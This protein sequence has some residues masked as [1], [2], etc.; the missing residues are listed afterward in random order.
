MDTQPPGLWR[1]LSRREVCRTPR[2]AV[3]SESVQLPNGRVV[4]DY[5]QFEMGAFAI[6]VAETT[7]HRTICERQYKHGVRQVILTLPGGQL[8]ASETPLAA[9][10]R[11]LLE[12]TGY[13]SCEWT[14]LGSFRTN[15]NQ[16]GAT[17]HYFHARS[18][19]QVQAPASGDLEDMTIELLPRAELIAAIGR[20]DF[21]V[22]TDIAAMC[23]ALLPGVRVSGSSSENDA[24]ERPTASGPSVSWL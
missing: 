14:A 19:R 11:E 16:G 23:L 24:A 7:D 8:E 2:I 12:E 9:A 15:C 4:D 10:Q 18:S 17:V 20:R 5:D 6:V 1:T 3:F 13:A 21:Q 22:V